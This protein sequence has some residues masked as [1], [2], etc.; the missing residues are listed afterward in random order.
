MRLGTS[1]RLGASCGCQMSPRAPYNC[2]QDATLAVKR[3]VFR[4]DRY[5]RTFH[6]LKQDSVALLSRRILDIRHLKSLKIRIRW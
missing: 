4:P 3:Q 5:E 1:G 2:D 6:Y